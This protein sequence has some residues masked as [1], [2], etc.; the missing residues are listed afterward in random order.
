MMLIP[1]NGWNNMNNAHEIVWCSTGKIVRIQ[2]RL[3]QSYKHEYYKAEQCLKMLNQPLK[4]EKYKENWVASWSKD[5]EIHR[6]QTNGFFTE[7]DGD[8]SL[9]FHV[10]VNTYT[11]R[12]TSSCCFHWSNFQAGQILFAYIG[13]VSGEVSLHL[14]LL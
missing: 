3:L 8:G 4:T 6:L 9:M 14:L 5:S 7:G 1:W 13:D 11:R 12:K 10:E 2:S